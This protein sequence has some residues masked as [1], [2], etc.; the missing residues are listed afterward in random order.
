MSFVFKERIMSVADNTIVYDGVTYKKGDTIPD[1]GSIGCIESQ[2]MLRKYTG[3]QADVA[4]LPTY[5]L[6]GS[7]CIMV[8]SG[9]YYVYESGSWVLHPITI[10][11]LQEYVS[12]TITGTVG[13]LSQLDTEDK[14]SIVNAINEVASSG[15]GGGGSVSPY[16]NNP[17]AL[18]TANAGSSAKYSRG[19][20][21][22]PMPT[23]SNVG[24]IPAPASATSGQF[25]VYNGSAWVAQT[26]PN[27]NGEKF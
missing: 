26:V 9:N 19:D 27:A 21:V 5:V 15:G 20:H 4:K 3:L 24:A 16:T 7:S 11:E 13:N 25:L 14:S 18:G 8:D 22:H 12:G 17:S 23:A 6:D 1:L 2:G 10:E